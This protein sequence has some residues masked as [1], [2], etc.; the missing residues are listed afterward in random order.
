MATKYQS[1]SRIPLPGRS[2]FRRPA[3]APV[4]R[5]RS[6]LGAGAA[7][8]QGAGPTWAV[9]AQS[10]NTAP[11]HSNINRTSFADTD[12]NPNS[13]LIVSCRCTSLVAE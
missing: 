6:R 1:T 11:Y 12:P 8:M 5:E 2:R 13:L 7:E 4:P 9:A 10:T 3:E